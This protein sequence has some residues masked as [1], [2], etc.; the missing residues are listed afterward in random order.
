[1]LGSDTGQDLLGQA[2]R[3]RL[4]IVGSRLSYQFA[5]PQIDRSGRVG[6]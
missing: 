5:S 1:M 4:S 2:S 3:S 6:R